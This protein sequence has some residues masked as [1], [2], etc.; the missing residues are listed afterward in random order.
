[1]SKGN[2]VLLMVAILSCFFLSFTLVGTWLAF[3]YLPSTMSSASELAGINGDALRHAHSDKLIE[4]A[5]SHPAQHKKQLPPRQLSIRVN[6]EPNPHV[7]PLQSYF[8]AS[9]AMAVKFRFV[10]VHCLYPYFIIYDV[11]CSS[12]S[13]VPVNIWY[14]DGGQGVEQGH[15]TLGQVRYSSLFDSPSFNIISIDCV[16]DNYQYL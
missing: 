13:K 15:L 10:F 7:K 1:M 4:N 2:N 3:E 9:T 16:G 12:L 6:Q 11:F 8:R 14:D 5:L